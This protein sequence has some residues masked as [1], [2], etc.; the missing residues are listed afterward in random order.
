MRKSKKVKQEKRN[1]RKSAEQNKRK[2]LQENKDGIPIYHSTI[3]DDFEDE[4]SV[5]QAPSSK[6]K[7]LDLHEG[8]TPDSTLSPEQFNKRL[9]VSKIFA[10]KNL[11][12]RYIVLLYKHLWEKVIDH[13]LSKL[14]PKEMP[15]F[16]KYFPKLKNTIYGSSEYLKCLKGMNPAL[17]HH[18]KVN[19]HHPEHF[20]NGIA[21]M[22]L[23]DLLEMFC[24]WYAATK[25]HSTGDIYKSLEINQD[26]FNFDD[27]LK[28]IFINSAKKLDEILEEADKESDEED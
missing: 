1:K 6:G 17:K 27:I 8:E 16:E 22:D 18:Y 13:D 19:A 10:H 3:L 12:R 4:E 20:K 2:D 15:Y 21:G 14:S 28:S 26:R 23:L 25:Q 9:V 7:L 5:V 24:Y 11:V